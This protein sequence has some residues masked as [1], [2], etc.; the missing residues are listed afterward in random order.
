[1]TTLYELE[2]ITIDLLNKLKNVIWFSNV[3]NWNSAD[4]LLVKNWIEA[5]QYCL[6]DDCENAQLDARNDFSILA[7]DYEK[8][9]QW[10]TVSATL[11]LLIEPLVLKKT[12]ILNSCVSKPE[13]VR[14]SIKWDI[15]LCAMA[16]EYQKFISFPYYNTIAQTYLNGHFP[17]GW[18]GVWPEGRLIVF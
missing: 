5:E 6:S 11:R 17:C 10:N 1:M 2:S 8:V 9:K 13:L 7:S 18:D 4:V 12:K 15:I 16:L 3:G 14:N